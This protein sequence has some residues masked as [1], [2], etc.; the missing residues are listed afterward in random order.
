[1]DNDDT[2][3]GE[4]VE[5]EPANYNQGKATEDIPGVKDYR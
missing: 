5:E 3:F 4:A 2:S 1:M